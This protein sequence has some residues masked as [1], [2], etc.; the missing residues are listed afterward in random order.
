MFR[1]G[2]PANLTGS[3]VTP[4]FVSAPLL[5]VLVFCA[6][7]SIASSAQTFTT[8]VNFAGTNGSTP[9]SMTLIQGI[10]GNL[11]G[12][13]S[14]G[15]AHNHGTVFKMTPGGTLNTIYSFCVK[16]NCA[17]GSMPSA[18][19][20]QATDGNFYGTTYFGGHVTAKGVCTSGCGT[21]FKITRGGVLTT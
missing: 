8:L 4:S 1:M 19:L 11:Y 16:T 2:F 12:T 17:D 9:Y 18:G 10:D 13:T 20:V 21:V 3:A 7:M 14:G 6:V 5:F 15:G